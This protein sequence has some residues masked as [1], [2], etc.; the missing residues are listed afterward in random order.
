MYDVKL[1]N[2]EVI[3]YINLT[4]TDKEA[5]RITGKITKG[6]NVID[7]FSFTILANN[8]GIS[9]INSLSTVVEVENTLT[10]TIEFRGRVLLPVPSMSSN[11]IVSMKVTCESELAY[12]KD[13][14]A[15]YAEFHDINVR[16]FLTK[17]IENHNNQVS[18]DKHFTVGNVEI[19]GNL[20]R[21]WSY[22]TTLD[23]I[24]ED[25]IDS[26]GGELRIRHENGIR[27]LDYINVTGRDSSAD[28]V[29]AKN[30]VSI[31]QELDPTEL[32]TRLIPL[33]AKLEDSDERL[34]I[35]SVNN[36]VIYID[37][38]ALIKE[39]GIVAK[40]VTWDDVTVDSNLLRKGKEYLNDNNRIK[41]AHK[42]SALDLSL[43]GLDFDS[44]EVGNY[45]YVI[46]DLMGINEKL[47]IISKTIL[48]ESPE[49]SELTIGDKFVGIK[50]YQLK[51]AKT[52]V[53]VERLREN[54]VSTVNSV[55]NITN[56]VTNLND[57]VTDTI[58]NLQVT[59]NNI[60]D[61]NRNMQL[62][63]ANANEALNGVKE[64]TKRC[65]RLETNLENQ[66]NKL[67]TIQR[68]L[69]MGV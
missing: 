57:T 15:M 24:K 35:A 32:V 54:L 59:N 50:D 65:E 27:Y 46:N 4:S 44:F 9:Q 55:V 61:I 38:E 21:F 5:P 62:I 36:D 66:K 69:A 28:I 42:I 67:I 30:L 22:D 8:P 64:L 26:L 34:T 58:D 18:S 7:S 48:I 16:D 40:T 37:D 2:K 29:I 49:S 20:Y 25:L 31:E 23:T 52:Q 41:K 39:F 14:I 17:L 1:I 47:R 12:L 33:G 3:T 11:G 56:D 10:R 6:I 60:L 19:E 63:N 13:S 53:S 43:I 51:A 45:H 68:R